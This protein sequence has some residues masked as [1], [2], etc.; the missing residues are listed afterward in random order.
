MGA[1]EEICAPMIQPDELC[2]ADDYKTQ[3]RDSRRPEHFSVRAAG[4]S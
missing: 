2:R 1:G 3:K 4:I